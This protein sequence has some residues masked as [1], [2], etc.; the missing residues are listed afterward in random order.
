[1]ARVRVGDIIFGRYQ[2]TAL[3]SREGG[4]GVVFRGEDRRLSRPVAIKELALGQEGGH[5]T[6]DDQE[7]INR[8]R[9]EAELHLSTPYVVQNFQFGMEHG[10]YYNVMEYVEGR[11]LEAVLAEERVMP[12]ARAVHIIDQICS[13]LDVAHKTGVIHRDIKPANI[14]LR[15]QGDVRITDFGIACFL[16][17]QRMTVLGSTLGSPLWSSPE[18]IIEPRDVDARTDVWSTGVLFYQMVTG[19]L[20]FQAKLLAD[21]YMKIVHD[22]ITPAK[23]LNPAISDEAN[24][25]IMKALE[26]DLG[27]RYSMIR[28]M[29]DDLPAE[30]R[31]API[32]PAALSAGAGSMMALPQSAE[33]GLTCAS[34]GTL[35]SPGDRFCARCGSGLVGV[36]GGTGPRVT[37]PSCGARIDTSSHFCPMCGSSLEPVVRTARLVVFGGIYVGRS[38]PLDSPGTDIGREANNRICLLQDAYVSRHHARIYGENGRHYVEG[39]DWLSQR[40]TTNGTYVNGLNID[41]QG[42]IPLHHGDTI[43]VGDTFFR[44]E[45]MA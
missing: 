26:R 42:R 28:E 30:F 8:F 44:F 32:P 31:A 5:L 29:Q 45:Q 21:L 2:V 11:S 17:K 37:C 13:G 24:N 27:K 43:R 25:C 14:M 40:K 12:E 34:C 41:G 3:I 7:L 22:P 16:T 35:N 18:Q 33:I 20:P 1:M 9:N 38:F 36:P 39:W 4:Q 23:D 6:A 10:C 19:Q 15:P